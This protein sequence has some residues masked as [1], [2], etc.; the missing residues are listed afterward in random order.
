MWRHVALLALL[1]CGSSTKSSKTTPPR[2]SAPAAAA[3]E[4][5][6]STVP[7]PPPPPDRSGRK[8]DQARSQGSGNR[9]DTLPV[10]DL[11]IDGLLD[12]WRDTR[13]VARVGAPADGA[14]EMH[15]AWDGTT[16]AFMLDIKDDRIVR[17]KG[18]HEDRVT[19]SLS[20]GE[21]P[22]TITVFP[23]NQMAKAKITKPARVE[24]ADS[25][26]PKGFSIE[27][28]IPA[29][30]VPGYSPSTP[31]FSLAL[32]F[33]DSDAATGGDTTPL[34]IEQPIELGDRKDLL[35]D[36][37][38]TV[39]LRRTDLKLDTLVDVD[40]DRKG[41][42]RV[43]AGGTVIGVLTE[44]FAYVTLPA[45]GPADIK[46]IDLL[47]LGA[48][49]HH[50]IAALVRQSG[51]GGSRDLLMLWTVWS[52]QLQPLVNI[53]VRKELGGNVLESSYAIGK[54]P[55]NV[56]ELVVEPRPAVGFSP[57]SWHEVPA[58]DSDSILLPW[59]D[60]K[61]GIAYS[62]KGAEIERRDLP[63]K[64]KK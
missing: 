44:Q 30:V 9:C 5:S 56:P 14:I 18:G 6:G 63:K 26:Q 61:A 17:V 50:V 1:G 46:K 64:K 16:I 4:P 19:L 22:V 12:D 25:L 31:A 53:E 35:D 20:A 43:V 51:N 10:A 8:G 57:E 41:K 39:R 59:D 15:C 58:G 33:H 52:G 49:G 36:F 7:P 21:R 2:E 62:L 29:A 32:V 27:I 42:E 34:A 38:A 45:A 23:G 40:P 55:R 11:S 24:V 48:K 47:P 54:G 13:V 3:S 60:K 28:A 37:L